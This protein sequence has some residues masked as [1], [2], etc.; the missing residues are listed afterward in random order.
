[1][2]VSGCDVGAY[3]HSGHGSVKTR[4]EDFIDARR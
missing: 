1:M 3:E 4:I 2:I